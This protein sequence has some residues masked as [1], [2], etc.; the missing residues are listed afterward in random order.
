MTSEPQLRTIIYELLPADKTVTATIYVDQ[1]QKLVGTIR[2]KLHLR[3]KKSI[4]TTISKQQSTTSS[5]QSP[6]FW[7]K[8]IS[9]LLNKWARV[10]DF[11][12][13]HIADP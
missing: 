5:R 10:T 1:L 9:D 4:N 13:K 8:V 6:E 7:A 12:G 11:N 3:E 2:E